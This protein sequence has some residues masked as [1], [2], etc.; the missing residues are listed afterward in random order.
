MSKGTVYIGTSGW[1][2]DSWEGRFYPDDLKKKDRLA[3]CGKRFGAVEINGSFYSLPKRESFEQ[4]AEAVPGDFR[5]SVKASRFLTHMKKLKDPEEPLEKLY[6]AAEG[7]GE[8]LAVVLYQLP[9]KWGCNV[10]RLKGLLEAAPDE[11][12]IAVEFRDESWHGEEVWET[13][14]ERGA[15]FCIY[16]L[17][18]ERSPRE[19]TAD[20][21]YI[22]LHG[23]RKKAYT[24][25]YSGQALRAWADFIEEQRDGGR[26]VYCFFDNDEM[27]KAPEDAQRLQEMVGD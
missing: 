5:F 27:A 26:D 16:D 19:V 23:P 12:R 11:P 2:Y 15:A 18:G 9:P 14:R 20:F 6:G 3:Y 7:M 21:V 8:K 13:L 4:W 22:R 24:G 25:S 17:K 10:D 1:T